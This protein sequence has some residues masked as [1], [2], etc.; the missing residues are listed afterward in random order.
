MKDAELYLAHRAASCDH[1]R[2][3]ADRDASDEAADAIPSCMRWVDGEQC[4]LFDDGSLE[5]DGVAY[6]SN[7]EFERRFQ[8]S[9]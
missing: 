3:H 2:S 8:E 5:C 6:E 9:R 4:R 7:D 1:S